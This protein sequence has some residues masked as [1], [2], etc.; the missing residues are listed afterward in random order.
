ML[1]PGDDM[2]SETPV[3]PDGLGTVKV[4]AVLAEPERDGVRRN[5]PQAVGTQAIAIRREHNL[6]FR[7]VCA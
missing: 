1:Q 7:P 6:D 5:Q 4:V 2:D 3:R